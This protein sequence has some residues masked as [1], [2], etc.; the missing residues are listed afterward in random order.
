MNEKKRN[1]YTDLALEVAET[2]QQT[3]PETDIDGVRMSV[4]HAC[5]D[6]IVTTWVEIHSA[7]GARQMGRPEGNYVTIESALMKEND[8]D[9][10]EDIIKIVTDQL[11]RL[12][13]PAADDV[14]LVVGLGNRHVTPDALGPHVVS[15]TL[16]TRH[17][18]DSLAPQL[19]DA[20]RAVAAIAPGVMGTTGIETVELVRGLVN[21]I[22]PNLVIAID[23]LAARHTRRINATIQMS[24]TG[25]SPGGGMGDCRA[26]LDA[27]TLGVPVIGIGV[28]TV[29]DAATLVN[30]TLDIMTDNMMR[31]M[32]EGTAFFRALRNLDEDEKYMFIRESL[33]PYAG[34]MF[35]TPKEV[36]SVIERLSGIIANALNIA[37]HPGI[38]RED[39]NRFMS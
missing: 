39:I 24:D 1:I 33:D 8:V 36:D 25:V 17:V 4:E 19:S 16:V 13:Q 14:I 29:V 9:A 23:A 35:V 2:I 10:H 32:P 22:K 30:D 20:V 28:P 11:V 7:E 27:E 12:A 21:R 38:S 37:L 34:N 15:K 6:T 3:R 5:G 31:L 26:R 18:M